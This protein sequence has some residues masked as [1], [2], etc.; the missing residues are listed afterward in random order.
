MTIS[1]YYVDFLRDN[2]YQLQQYHPTRLWKAN[3]LQLRAYI[4]GDDGANA[5]EYYRKYGGAR[6]SSSATIDLIISPLLSFRSGAYGSF[7]ATPW[8]VIGRFRRFER[9]VVLLHLLLQ[10]AT[11]GLYTNGKRRACCNH[12][13]CVTYLRHRVRMVVLA[14]VRYVGSVY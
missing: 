5:A 8:L 9:I 12:S 13:A 6:K 10:T 7:A 3:L 1:A 14:A 4:R 11:G 2:R